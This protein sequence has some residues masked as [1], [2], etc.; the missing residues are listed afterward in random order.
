VHEALI[1]LADAKAVDLFDWNDVPY[2][3]QIS[4]SEARP[5]D[6]ELLERAD[7]LQSFVKSCFYFNE[8]SLGLSLVDMRNDEV[9]TVHSERSGWR[10]TRA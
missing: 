6:R 8:Q 1:V 9:E 10:L 5:T 7:W 4:N 3:L 2:V